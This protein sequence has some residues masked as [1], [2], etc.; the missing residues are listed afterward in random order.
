MA[1]LVGGGVRVHRGS[2]EE[3]VMKRINI[4]ILSVVLAIGVIVSSQ[5]VHAASVFSNNA[6]DWSMVVRPDT[7][8]DN[9][10]Y[11]FYGRLKL[12]TE[13]AGLKKFGDVSGIE[14]LFT[15]PGLSL[16]TNEKLLPLAAIIPMP[17]NCQTVPSADSGTKG[18]IIRC[19]T[20]E[21]Y[22][23]EG[24]DVEGL[25]VFGAAEDLGSSGWEE[26]NIVVFETTALKANQ[27]DSDADLV[28]DYV[29]NCPDVQNYDQVDTDLNGVGDACE[30]EEEEEEEEQSDDPLAGLTDESGDG[31]VYTPISMSGEGGGACSLIAR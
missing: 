16:V 1:L 10:Q 28:P 4:V 23:K 29:D 18:E 5:V 11:G 21:F 8:G 17:S 31:T 13:Y 30:P 7:S 24:Y 26:E 27:S 6:N 3:E 2:F 22:P 12:G 15:G 14:T 19:I 20:I 25:V 9:L